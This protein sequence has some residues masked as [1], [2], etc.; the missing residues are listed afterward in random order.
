MRVFQLIIS[1]IA[2]LMLLGMFALN[3][4]VNKKFNISETVKCYLPM[5]IITLVLLLI[6][7]ITVFIKINKQL[8]PYKMIILQAQIMLR[9]I[10]LFNAKRRNRRLPYVNDSIQSDNNFI[11]QSYYLRAATPK[12]FVFSTYALP[13]KSL[14]TSC[15]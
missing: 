7:I 8:S 12:H 11:C 13:V 1:V 3:L 4:W 6:T 10:I 2:F 14:H 5:N 9:I 15:T